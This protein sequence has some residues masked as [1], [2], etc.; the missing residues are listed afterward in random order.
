MGGMAALCA[1]GFRPGIGGICGSLP[2][3]M[4]SGMVQS[5]AD[6]FDGVVIVH[7]LWGGFIGRGFVGGDWVFDRRADE[8]GGRELIFCTGEG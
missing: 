8:G 6:I 1:L 4:A 3:C 5:L 2:E 7:H